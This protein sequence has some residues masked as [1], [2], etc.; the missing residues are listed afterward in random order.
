MGESKR[1]VI[2]S[3]SFPSIIEDGKCDDGSEQ[4]CWERE[5]EN[6]RRREEGISEG[7]EYAVSIV[8][9]EKQESVRW[10]SAI[11]REKVTL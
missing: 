1:I 5:E 10:V 11:E 4:C 2:G 9:G 7:R 8:G 6:K 3:R